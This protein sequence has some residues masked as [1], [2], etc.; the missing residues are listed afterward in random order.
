MNLGAHFLVS[1]ILAALFYPVLGLSS[2]WVFAGG[3]LIDVDHPIYYYFKFKSL[4]LKKAYS[5]FRNADKKGYRKI[6]R[7]FHN[8]E[9]VVI[10]GIMSMFSRIILITLIGLFTHLIMDMIDEKRTYVEI[11]GYSILLRFIEKNKTKSLIK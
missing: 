8:I 1:T 10:L 11:S 7:I 9:T 4:N 3:F 5:F 6:I 2:L